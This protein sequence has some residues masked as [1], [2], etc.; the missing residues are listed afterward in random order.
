MIEPLDHYEPPVLPIDERLK[1]E[2]CSAA[3]E[4]MRDAYRLLEDA[5]VAEPFRHR[6][7]ELATEIKSALGNKEKDGFDN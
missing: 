7:M 1:R 3:I 6:M 5:G 4:H 2:R